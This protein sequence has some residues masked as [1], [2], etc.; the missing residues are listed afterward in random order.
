M[1]CLTAIELLG[2]ASLGGGVVPEEMAILKRKD[3]TQLEKPGNSTPN[4][5]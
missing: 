3:S 2:W 1:T 4:E 5:L